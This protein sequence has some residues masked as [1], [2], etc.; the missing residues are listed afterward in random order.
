MFSSHF[1]F[2]TTDAVT[3]ISLG[4]KWHTGSQQGQNLYRRAGH[5]PFPGWFFEGGR[6]R[7]DWKRSEMHSA[8][9]GADQWLQQQTDLQLG[10]PTLSQMWGVKTI[11]SYNLAFMTGFA[12]W[13]SNNMTIHKVFCGKRV[14]SQTSEAFPY[15][16]S[17]QCGYYNHILFLKMYYVLLKKGLLI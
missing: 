14:I 10:F 3:P 7:C 2:G 17:L 12:A 4:D 1:Y 16:F 8:L 6:M 11:I 13:R 5:F 9:M 15:S